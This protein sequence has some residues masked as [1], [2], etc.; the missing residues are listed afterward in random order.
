VR[1]E[2]RRTASQRVDLIELRNEALH[3]GR[4]ERRSC[5]RNV[6]MQKVIVTR[7]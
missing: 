3:K 6:R 2:P 5:M 4:V 7:V 1:N